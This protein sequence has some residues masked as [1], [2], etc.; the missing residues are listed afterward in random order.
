M[1]PQQG[2]QGFPVK[3]GQIADGPHPEPLQGVC[4][5]P[6][7]IE[8]VGHRQR[9]DQGTKVIRRDQGDGVR[10]FVVA[11]QLGKHLVEGDSHRDGQAQLP[12]HPTAELVGQGQG[13]P[14]EE[15]ERAS[16]VQ[17]ALVDAE[18]FHQIGVLLIEL[19]YLAGE[20]PVLVVV[21]GKENQPG[22]LFPGLPDGLRGL[23]TE[24]L[25]RL[26][27]CK[28][29][30]VAAGRV[31]AHRH[32]EVAQFRVVQQ[33]HRGVKAVQITVKDDTVHRALPPY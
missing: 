33:L 24:G 29:D 14:A 12:P 26:V 3:P 1:A 2:E 18:G 32:W 31:A 30:A 10:F 9:P 21:G 4:R 17:P 11:A 19:V 13:V 25:G 5:S 6:A 16:D 20:L 15:V 28:D 8:Q 23:D 7:H 22:T 27:F